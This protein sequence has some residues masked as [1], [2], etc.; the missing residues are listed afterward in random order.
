MTVAVDTLTADAAGDCYDNPAW[1]E[2]AF[3]FRDLAAEVAV[4]EQL[5]AR[6]APALG[7]EVVQLACG[8][9]QHLP[10]FADRGYRY[11]GV[12]ISAAMLDHARRRAEG[13]KAPAWFL[14]ASMV[15]FALPAPVDIVFVALGDL[16]VTSAAELDQHLD[17]ICAALKPGGLYLM[18][19]CVQFQPEKTF[20]TQGDGWTMERDGTRIDARVT[21]RPASPVEQTFDEI[22]DLD[23]TER[24]ATVS[25]QSIARKYALYPRQF[26]SLIAA[27][28]DFEFVGWW[29]NWNPDEPL[30]AE[31]VDI[32]RPITLL[33]KVI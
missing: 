2:L 13:V 33:R 15:D 31:T 28:T 20:A 6:Y 4:I 23:V 10:A 3:D 32:Y 21:M 29:N 25:L 1:Y 11:G 22:L 7:R 24:G 16:Y 17:A 14:E 19:W 5:R 18:D 12:D 30:T 9:A 8:P 27:R 26:L